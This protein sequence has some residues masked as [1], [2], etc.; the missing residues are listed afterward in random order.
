MNDNNERFI[1]SYDPFLSQLSEGFTVK[2]F[3][4]NILWVVSLEPQD[5]EYPTNVAGRAVHI[6]PPSVF[7][8]TTALCTQTLADPI[9]GHVNPRRLLQRDDLEIL[10]KLYPRATGAQVH[11]S[12]FI[13]LLFKSRAILQE[14]WTK[15]GFLPTF[16]GLRVRFTILC[17]RPPHTIHPG[18]SVRSQPESHLS[19]ACLGLKLRS[20]EPGERI[21]VPTHAF[22]GATD[23]GSSAR[24]W[25]TDAEIRMRRHL[26]RFLTIRSSRLPV[27]AIFSAS[28][29]HARTP[30]GQAV[31]IGGTNQVVGVITK[32]FDQES[33][34]NAR[35]SFPRDFRHDLSLV[36]PINDSSLPRLTFPD[37]SQNIVRWADYKQVLEG[38]PIFITGQNVLTRNSVRRDEMTREAGFEGVQ[39]IWDS[40]VLSVDVSFLW[41]TDY[42]GDMTHGLSGAILCLGKPTDSKCSG[43]VFQ[44]FEI[45]IKRKTYLQFCCESSSNVARPNLKGGFL[46]HLRFARQP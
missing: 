17:Q 46:F 19:S 2:E 24:L 20:T 14:A 13:T 15:S 43:V 45:P 30:L 31:Y 36:T 9:P 41:R 16:G 18:F 42:D 44:N 11:V 10:R 22:V 6:V 34:L 32:T 3:A 33:E 1:R 39:Y 12:G 26:S 29:P 4:G 40:D 23:M 21:T 37:N 25:L 35:R 27:P 8:N 5:I 38:S 7:P 28:G